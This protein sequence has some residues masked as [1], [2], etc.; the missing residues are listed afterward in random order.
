VKFFLDHRD[1]FAY[2]NDNPSNPYRYL[3]PPGRMKHSNTN[4]ESSGQ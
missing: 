4:Q 1:A 2:S 3:E